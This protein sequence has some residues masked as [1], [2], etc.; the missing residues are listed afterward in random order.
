MSS[1]NDRKSNVM[2]TSTI[3]GDF[4]VPSLNFSKNKINFK[5]LWEKGVPMMPI[6]QTLDMTCGSS[7][8][9]NFSLKTS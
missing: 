3:V 8:P 1:A 4:I 2:L 9:T 7:L 5:Y 6:S